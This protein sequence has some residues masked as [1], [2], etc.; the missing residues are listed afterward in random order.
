MRRPPTGKR[1]HQVYEPW[2]ALK[3]ENPE[4]LE[5]RDD[6]DRAV[7]GREVQYLRD[8]VT[9]PPGDDYWKPVSY[10]S[11]LETLEKIPERD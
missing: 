7:V 11:E 9:R 6:L 2:V 5:S 4:G 3:V 10:L 1:F 8:W